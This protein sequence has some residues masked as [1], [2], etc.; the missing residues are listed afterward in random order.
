M[1]APVFVAAQ[2]NRVVG[3]LPGCYPDETTYRRALRLI[4]AAG[5]DIVEIGIP[6]AVPGLEGATITRALSVV[7]A[8]GI[9]EI[10]VVER[11][12][13]IAREE[14][15]N[16][17]PMAFRGTVFERI[18]LE[19]F[20]RAAVENGARAVLVPDAGESERRQLEEA[21]ADS[22]IGF[23]HFLAAGGA[24]RPRIDSAAAFAYLQTAD[25]PTGG[26]F[27]PSPELRRR[28]SAAKGTVPV[29]IG[30]G[31]RTPEQVTRAL[32]LG[33]DLVIVGT[34]M[35]DALDSGLE[36]FETYI[37]SIAAAGR[38]ER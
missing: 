38:G 14:G 23:V 29:A 26:S 16:P 12:T 6:G 25:M 33:V 30:F 19:R 15:L 13:R 20:L 4:A 37:A 24:E 27:E 28:I 3:Y 18:G 10:T 34:A 31:I 17:I 1:A 5:I 11:G 22:G 8:R 32:S 35:V 9:D 21:A 7:E 36:A 2:R